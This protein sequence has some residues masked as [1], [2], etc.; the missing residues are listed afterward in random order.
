MQLNY[1]TMETYVTSGKVQIKSKMNLKNMKSTIK[2]SEF[3]KTTI[4]YNICTVYQM[5]V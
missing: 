1:E 3:K 2:I 5:K 4:S